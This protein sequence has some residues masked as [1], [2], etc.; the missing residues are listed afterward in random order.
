[1]C[2]MFGVRRFGSIQGFKGDDFDPEAVVISGTCTKTSPTVTGSGK[3]AMAFV[4]GPS[5]STQFLLCLRYFI[6]LVNSWNGFIDLS[7]NKKNSSERYLLLV[8]VVSDFAVARRRLEHFDCFHSRRR[9][10]SHSPA[11]ERTLQT[12]KKSRSVA[13][14]EK[15]ETGEREREGGS[16]GAKSENHRTAARQAPGEG[17]HH[18]ERCRTLIPSAASP[19]TYTAAVPWAPRRRR[20]PSRRCATSR[21]RPR[22]GWRRP[23]APAAA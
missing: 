19:K 17:G 20:R 2:Y 3:G 4:G 11:L 10:A 23:G 16:A 21:D 8:V 15:A 12:G 9:P 22:R 7:R 6:L 1:M 5:S 14:A 13:Q 18:G